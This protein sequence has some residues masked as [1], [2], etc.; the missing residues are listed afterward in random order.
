MDPKFLP[1]KGA[2]NKSI[3]K[4]KK[5]VS[6]YLPVLTIKQDARCICSH[7]QPTPNAIHCSD[8]PI[9]V[10][11]TRNDAALHT[12]VVTFI[13]YALASVLEVR[14]QQK[15]EQKIWIAPQGDPRKW[16]NGRAMQRV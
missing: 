2:P 10:H 15:P 9:Y 11:Q 5:I 1:N 13:A 16:V 8:L 12:R 3:T 4:N 6:K 7:G 14:T